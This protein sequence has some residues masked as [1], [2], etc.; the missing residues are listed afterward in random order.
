[1]ILAEFEVRHSRPIAP[2]R[3]IALGEVFLPTDPAPGFG[4]LLLGSLV[5]ACAARLD[6][7]DRDG[8]DAFLAEVEVGRKIVQPRLRHRFQKDTHGLDRSRHRLVGRGEHIDLHIDGHG[9]AM[10]QILAAIYVA[11][12]LDRTARPSV[13]RLLRR[14]T[15]WQGEADE[16]LVGFLTAERPRAI[17]TGDEGWALSVLG[18][19]GSREPTRGEINRR[20]RQLVRDAHPDHGA[21]ADEAGRRIVDLSE[22]KRILLS[23]GTVE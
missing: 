16:H 14:A 4:G 2:T 20:F 22:A 1:V 9:A 13:F 7:E 6:D 15:R 18:F 19:V 12:M 10:P 5:G 8:L 21:P 17:G 3:R 11:G 23:V